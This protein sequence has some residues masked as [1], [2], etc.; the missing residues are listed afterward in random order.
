MHEIDDAKKCARGIDVTNGCEDVSLDAGRAMVGVGVSV[1]TG[2]LIYDLVTSR[3][4]VREYNS[5]YK[6][7]VIPMMSQSSTGIAV[8]GAF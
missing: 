4:E 1:Y 2:S 3:R 5:H 8:G 6:I 7:Q